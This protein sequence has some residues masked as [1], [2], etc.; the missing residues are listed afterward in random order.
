MMVDLKIIANP[1]EIFREL[2]IIE[3]GRLRLRRLMTRD[4]NDV[5]EY[6]SDSNVSKY[7]TW[8]HHRSVADSLHFI[9][10][11]LN[12]YS[13]GEPTSWG[14]VYKEDRKLIGTGGYHWWQIESA[15]AEIGYA[16][17]SRYWNMG[18]MT[19]ALQAMIEFGFEK[20]L[21]NRIEARCYI[22]NTASE[23]V[24]Q[25]C[26]MKY[27]GI[28]RESLYVKGEFQDLKLY[29]ILKK[30]FDEIKLKNG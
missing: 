29:S 17:Y 25:K 26:G 27:E 2:P 15:R 5:Y 16:I 23:R 3:T 6:A 8:E 28:M 21:L 4:A 24:L 12:S 20:M 14:I 22:K 18:I 10:M 9:R 13:R 1:Q 11:V 7:V 19:E 30:E